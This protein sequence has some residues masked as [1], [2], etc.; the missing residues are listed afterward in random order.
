MQSHPT[1]GF[2]ERLGCGSSCTWQPISVVSVRVPNGLFA[3]HFVSPDGESSSCRKES[4]RSRLVQTGHHL[5]RRDRA[6]APSPGRG[7]NAFSADRDQQYWLIQTRFFGAEQTA[8]LHTQRH[9]DNWRHA[10]RRSILTQ[11]YSNLSGFIGAEHLIYMWRYLFTAARR[12]TNNRFLTS[13]VVNHLHCCSPPIS[14][15]IRATVDVNWLSPPPIFSSNLSLSNNIS[16]KSTKNGR[17]VP[18]SSSLLNMVIK[19]IHQMEL[20]FFLLSLLTCHFCRW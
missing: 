14:V 9:E 12:W 10:S 5:R 6:T 18:F 4:P 2:W 17:S 19:M 11:T 16:F 20:V 3:A 1:P 8:N 15:L 7:L 13:R